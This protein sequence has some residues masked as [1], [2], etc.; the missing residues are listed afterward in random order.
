MIKS[1]TEGSRGRTG[2]GQGGDRRGHEPQQG[3]TCPER[4][5]KLAEGGRGPAGHDCVIGTS[6]LAAHS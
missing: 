4:E 6:S 5:S 2:K 1:W 3:P